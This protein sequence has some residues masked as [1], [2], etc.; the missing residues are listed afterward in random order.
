MLAVYKRLFVDIDL[1]GPVRLRCHA[2][3]WELRRRCMQ[4]DALLR[5]AQCAA[6]IQEHHERVAVRLREYASGCDEVVRVLAAEVHR[7]LDDC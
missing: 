6:V 1:Y 7:Y 3:A 5:L 4:A 2:A